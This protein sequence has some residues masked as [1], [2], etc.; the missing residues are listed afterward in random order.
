MVLMNLVEK[1][2]IFTSKRTTAVNDQRSHANRPRCCS[3]LSVVR[4]RKRGGINQHH[5][6]NPS[7]SKAATGGDCIHKEDQGRSTMP[8]WER[9]ASRAGRRGFLHVRVL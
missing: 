4:C 2:L 9:E 7:G 6:A 8:V 1:R 3:Q 5:D